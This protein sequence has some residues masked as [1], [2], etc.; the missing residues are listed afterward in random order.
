M[1]ELPAALSWPI[2]KIAKV[3]AGS[4]RSSLKRAFTHPGQYNQGK[5]ETTYVHTDSESA[6][7]QVLGANSASGISR[8]DD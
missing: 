6:A 5:T 4:L 8:I 7:N 2:R 1:I 3:S